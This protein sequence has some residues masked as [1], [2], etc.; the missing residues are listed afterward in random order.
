MTGEGDGLQRRIQ[1]HDR[2][3]SWVTAEADTGSWQGWVMGYDRGGYRVMTG[4]GHGLQ[5]RRIQ[6][7]DRDG[8]W[9]TAEADT[10]S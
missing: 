8:S 9:V 1:G 5:Q 10:G 4:M 7:L 6:G 3:G 2:D